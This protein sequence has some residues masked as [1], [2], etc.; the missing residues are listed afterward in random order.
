MRLS[1]AELGT[2]GCYLTACRV[3]STGSGRVVIWMVLPTML[4]TMN[5]SIPSLKAVNGLVPIQY[6]TTYLPSPSLVRRPPCVLKLFL[7]F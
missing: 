2:L 1:I 3:L 4:E 6:F 5:M 7:I